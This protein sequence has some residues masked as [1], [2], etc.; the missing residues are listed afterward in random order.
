M[1]DPIPEWSVLVLL[2]TSYVLELKDDCSAIQWL[3]QLFFIAPGDNVICGCGFQA[4]SA[5]NP[6]VMIDRGI[7][8]VD[9]FP[10]VLDHLLTLFEI[11]RRVPIV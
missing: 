9:G 3:T 7:A 4:Y 5:R 8:L 2:T 1:F 11:G 6:H 10:L